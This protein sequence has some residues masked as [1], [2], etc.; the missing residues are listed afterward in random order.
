MKMGIQRIVTH[1]S[2]LII[3]AALAGCAV[4]IGSRSQSTPTPEVKVVYVTNTVPAA[5]SSVVAATNVSTRPH[6]NMA[7]VPVS[8]TGSATNRQS[9]VLQRVKDNPGSC[10]IIF[11]GDSITQGW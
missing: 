2:L 3:A 5:A 4:S 10:D 1:S 8:R 6:T 11:I 9:Q 7:I